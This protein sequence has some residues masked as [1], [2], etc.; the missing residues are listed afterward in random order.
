MNFITHFVSIFETIGVVRR[1]EGLCSLLL[2]YILEGLSGSCLN[3]KSYFW[4]L[5]VKIRAK[6]YHVL[7]Y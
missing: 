2:K 4:C 7:E 6:K 5:F 1:T 3:K